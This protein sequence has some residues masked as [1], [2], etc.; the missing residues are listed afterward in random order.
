VKGIHY[1]AIP[2]SS[3]IADAYV[4]LGTFPDHIYNEEFVKNAFRSDMKDDRINLFSGESLIIG[5]KTSSGP[6]GVGPHEIAH[7]LSR[8]FNG[9]RTKVIFTIRNQ[10]DALSS[11][12]YHSRGPFSSPT[13][14]WFYPDSPDTQLRAV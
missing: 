12:Y 5:S 11:H 9:I 6:I 2:S 14:E 4:N 10:V 7:R 13:K 3:Q 1:L 8:I